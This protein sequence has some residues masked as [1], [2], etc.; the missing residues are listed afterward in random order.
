M[1]FINF[2]SI[3][4]GL[5]QERRRWGRH[6]SPSQLRKVTNKVYRELYHSHKQD[7]I[8]HPSGGGKAK[9]REIGDGRS[10]IGPDLRTTRSTQVSDLAAT[11][12]FPSIFDLRTPGPRIS[13]F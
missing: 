1:S 3:R 8:P 5:W 4:L 10:K 7:A 6:S 2:Y 11:V 13:D 12:R 9:S